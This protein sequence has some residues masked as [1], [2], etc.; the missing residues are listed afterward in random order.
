MSID[1][2]QFVLG[3]AGLLEPLSDPSCAPLEPDKP[4]ALEMDFMAMSGDTVTLD[5]RWVVGGGLLA[6]FRERRDPR[7]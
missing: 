3:A 7:R 1:E 4:M 6:L 5:F 2:A